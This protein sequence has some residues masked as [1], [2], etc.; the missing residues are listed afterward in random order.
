MSAPIVNA[1][2]VSA[3][4]VPCPI[5]GAAFPNAQQAATCLCK[6]R[7]YITTLGIRYG[8]I[9]T[10][11]DLWSLNRQSATTVVNWYNSR[12]KAATQSYGNTAPAAHQVAALGYL[13]IPVPATAALADQALIAA[14]KSSNATS[15][16]V[17]AMAQHLSGQ[18]AQQ[19]TLF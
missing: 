8:K 7:R 6:R 15:G 5:C 1:A 11:A 18:S 10:A 9:P 4:V 3:A 14:F 16:A 2:V 13:G 19:L 12:L 17:W